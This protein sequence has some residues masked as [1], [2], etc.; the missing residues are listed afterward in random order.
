[1]KR[2]LITGAGG[3]LGKEFVKVL[4]SKGIDFVA[5]EKKDLDITNFGGFIRH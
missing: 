1:M 3:Q 4:S 2:V 5:L